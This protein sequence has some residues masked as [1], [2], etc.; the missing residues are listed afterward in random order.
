[1]KYAATRKLGRRMPL[2]GFMREKRENGQIITH[3]RERV[4]GPGDVFETDVDFGSWVAS[5]YLTVLKEKVEPEKVEPEKV[6]P[7]KVE[8]EKVEPERAEPERAEPERAEPER[9]EVEVKDDVVD[10]PDGPYEGSEEEGFRCLICD[11]TYNPSPRADYYMERHLLSEHG[12]K[13]S[14]RE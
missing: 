1:M 13:V 12:I 7:E 11:K 8:P 14:I 2:V 9:V 4:V 10:V 3:L 5:G 6:E